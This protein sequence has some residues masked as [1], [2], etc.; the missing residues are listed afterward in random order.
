MKQPIARQMRF[1]AWRAFAGIFGICFVLCTAS[2][3]G[4]AKPAASTTEPVTSASSSI[5]SGLA[6]DTSTQQ[7][8]AVSSSPAAQPSS[9]VDP[10]PSPTNQEF[11]SPS[12]NISCEIDSGGGASTAAYCQTMSPAQSV[13]LSSSGSVKVCVGDSCVGN[14]GEGTPTV[15]YGS[16]VD[17]AGFH[18]T[19]AT[20]GMSC[21][22]AGRGFEISRTAITPTGAPVLEL[23]PGSYHGTVDSVDAANANM[24]YTIT[25]AGCGAAPTSGSWTINL[26]G[27]VFVANSQ[28]TTAQGQNVTVIQSQWVAAVKSYKTWDVVVASGRPIEITD[29]PTTC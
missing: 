6:S 26:K 1:I 3:T 12:G 24:V 5:P 14:P 19:S 10:S 16:A 17:I 8:S 13:T 25:S 4:S 21:T 29:G 22:I 9:A 18:C 23:G 7:S 28:P 20:S 15:A 2:C 27:A 11:L